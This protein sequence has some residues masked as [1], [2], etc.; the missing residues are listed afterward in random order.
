MAPRKQLVAGVGVAPTEAEL[1]RLARISFSPHLK[2][3][4]P[5][6][7]SKRVTDA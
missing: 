4:L 6:R 5:G 7:S 1:M 2:I 3:G